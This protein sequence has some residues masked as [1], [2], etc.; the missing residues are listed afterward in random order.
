MD[1]TPVSRAD[2]IAAATQG[3]PAPPD[4]SQNRDLIAAV[5][6]VNQTELFGHDQELTFSMDRETRKLVIRL[7]DRATNEVIREIPPEYVLRAAE[8]SRKSQPNSAMEE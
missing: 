5:R 4:V 8:D 3:V 2:S 7:V 1:T 6:A